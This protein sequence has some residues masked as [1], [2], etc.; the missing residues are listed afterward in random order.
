M[1]GEQQRADEN[2]SSIPPLPVSVEAQTPLLVQ[3][4][5][6]PLEPVTWAD[7]RQAL[8]NWGV[9]ALLVI[10][11]ASFTLWVAFL[12]P[13]QYSVLDCG[14]RVTVALA[15]PRYVSTGDESQLDLTACNATTVP[16]TSTLVVDFLG[17]LPVQV[18][19]D[20]SSDVS[21]CKFPPGAVN[22]SAVPFHICKPPLWFQRGAVDFT[23]QLVDNGNP[24]TCVT[25]GGE[26]IHRITLCPFHGLAKY[27]RWFRLTPLALVGA[28]LWEWAKKRLPIIG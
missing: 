5:H 3:L 19:A 8:Q 11:F 7:L 10:I 20:E 24:T 14:G 26:D 25:S 27:F 13:R 12:F 15:Y 28:A 21:L 4:E 23:V 6:P 22:G 9:I 1:P 16:I 2:G 18:E 17:P